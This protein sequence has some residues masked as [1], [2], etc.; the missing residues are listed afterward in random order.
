MYVVLFIAVNFVAT[1]KILGF[2]ATTA[3]IEAWAP[4]IGRG[5]IGSTTYELGTSA[6]PPPNQA[7]VD[8]K[9]EGAAQADVFR[10]L[11][12]SVNLQISLESWV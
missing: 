1:V 12:Q 6:G 2:L 10:L 3:G 7:P 8:L 5:S 9:D 11:M 4:Q